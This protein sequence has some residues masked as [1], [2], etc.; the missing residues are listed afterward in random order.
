MAGCGGQPQIPRIPVA[1]IVTVDGTPLPK[2]KVV[3]TPAEGNASLIAMAQVVDGR[4][5]T[6]EAFGAIPGV[7]RV[8][9]I[10]TDDGGYAPDDEAAMERWV[11]GGRKP[12]K[13]VRIPKQYQKDGKLK[14]EVKTGGPNEFKFE[15]ASSEK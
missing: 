10:S 1:G 6:P 7:Q 2:G 9:I 13:V 14:A 15:L 11:A 12:I 5:E 4:F 3:F 8:E